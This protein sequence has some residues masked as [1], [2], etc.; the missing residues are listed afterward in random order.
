MIVNSGSSESCKPAGP[1]L[2]TQSRGATRAAWIRN[3]S[4]GNLVGPQHSGVYT[5]EPRVCVN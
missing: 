2:M 3:V 1:L 5:K 4:V